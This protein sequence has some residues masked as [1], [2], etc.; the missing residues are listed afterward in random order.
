MFVILGKIEPHAG[1]NKNVKQEIFLPRPKLY[2]TYMTKL[3]LGKLIADGLLLDKNFINKAK[4]CNQ[5]GSQAILGTRSNRYQGSSTASP[6]STSPCRARNRT[7][8]R[9][10]RSAGGPGKVTRR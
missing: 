9:R 7:I 6:T 5:L 4:R 3:R 2:L 10:L 8:T 1:I